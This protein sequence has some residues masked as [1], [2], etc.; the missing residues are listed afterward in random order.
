MGKAPLKSIVFQ[1]IRK[2]FTGLLVFCNILYEN[3]APVD[4]WW[5][6][7]LYLSGWK[8]SKKFLSFFVLIFSKQTK[9]FEILCIISEKQDF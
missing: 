8:I 2:Y 3:L 1:V 7:Q 4:F 5:K 6:N 9:L